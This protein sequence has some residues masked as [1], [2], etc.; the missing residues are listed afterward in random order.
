M[1]SLTFGNL[2]ENTCNKVIDGFVSVSSSL[3]KPRLIWGSMSLP[4]A[5]MGVVTAVSSSHSHPVLH[6]GLWLS[7]KTLNYFSRHHGSFLLTIWPSHAASDT[8]SVG[9]LCCHNTT[10]A[11]SLEPP[12]TISDTSS[13]FVRSGWV[14]RAIKKFQDFHVL[15][16]LS[17]L[18]TWKTT[19]LS[20]HQIL[21]EDNADK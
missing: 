20:F 1:K 21:G 11:S 8:E 4:S 9:N 15:D 3:L 7:S 13:P 16:S 14:F 2:L 5:H 10:S 6:I 18:W 12:C 17:P 19:K